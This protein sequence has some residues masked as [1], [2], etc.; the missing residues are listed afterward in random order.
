M[1]RCILHCDMNNFY[2]SVECMLNPHLRGHPVAVCGETEERHGIVL[3][4]NYEAK[5]FGVTTGEAV[6]QAKK[7]CPGLITVPPHFEEYLRIS[8]QARQIYGR[9]TDQIEPMGL[10]ECWLDVTGSRR[11]FGEGEDLAFAIKDSIKRELGVTASVGVSF[12]KVFAKL[13]SDMKKPDAVTVIPSD[14]FREL[15]WGLPASD[16]LGVGRATAKKL[17]AL[18]VFTIGDLA[19]Y[20]CERLR[21]KFGKCGEDLWRFANGLDRSRVVTRGL[22]DLD[23]TAGHGITTLRD[24]VDNEEVWGIMLAL[25]QDIGHRLYVSE[26]KAT[27]VAISVR[28]C[29]L[30][31]RGW[32]CQLPYPTRS[33][34]VLAKEAHALFVRSYSWEKPIRSL[35][36]RAISLVPDGTSYQIDFFT[37]AHAIERQEIVDRTVEEIRAKHGAASIRNAVLLCN[38]KMPGSDVLKRN[39]LSSRERDE[40]GRED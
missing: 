34:F 32:Q 30:M 21:V 31:S 36:V 8:A 26:R 17:L 28:D 20:P 38:P 25:T 37:D 14:R 18:G 4:K 1:N 39:V 40:N 23:K 11:F 7:K 24:L 22:N 6:W 12:N 9:Y 33:P 16:L 10:D 29:A 27:G 35:S 5:S 13:G 3:A 15:I 2:A 19:R